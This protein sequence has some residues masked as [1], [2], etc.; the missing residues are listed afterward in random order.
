MFTL[1]AERQSLHV[2][3]T[4]MYADYILY[5][6]L[7]AREVHKLLDLMKDAIIIILSPMV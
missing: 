3:K 7:K 1:H 4:I 6:A 2:H 5:L